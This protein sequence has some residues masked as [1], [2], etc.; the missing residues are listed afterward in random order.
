V[1]KVAILVAAFLAGCGSAPRDAAKGDPTAEEWYGRTV[2]QVAA[3]NREAESAYERGN[4]DQAA[5]LIKKAEPLVARV[6]DVRR[7]SLA[8]AEAA[9][10]LDDLY[11]RMLLAN[12]HYGWARFVFQ[13]NLSRWKHWQPQTEETERRRKQAE[14]EIAECDRRM[15]DH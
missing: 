10:D 1:R 11:G 12:R 13:K 14:M 4:G 5:A 7:P 9:G 2:A 3:L 15:E 8:A 6:L